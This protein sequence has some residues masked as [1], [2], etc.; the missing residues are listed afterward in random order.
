MPTPLFTKGESGNP[1]GRPKGSKNRSTEEIRSFIQRVVDN[2]LENLEADL[3]QMNNT[4]RWIILDKLSRY[5]MPQLTKNDNTNINTGEIT[6]KVEY[7]DGSI[8]GGQILQLTNEENI[9]NI[10]VENADYDFLIDR[11]GVEY[12]KEA[13]AN[14]EHKKS[15]G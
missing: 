6:I 7:Q 15:A 2:N 14:F 10:E 9:T 5:F 4:N 11:G 8:T 13:D 12:D 1:N 3:I